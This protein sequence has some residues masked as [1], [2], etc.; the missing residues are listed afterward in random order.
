[1]GRGPSRHSRPSEQPASCQARSRPTDGASGANQ[2]RRD[3]NQLHASPV[4]IRTIMRVLL[5]TEGSSCTQRVTPRYRR[6]RNLW[7]PCSAR[8]HRNVCRKHEAG[9]PVLND[10]MEEYLGPAR[11]F[12][13][14]DIT[15]MPCTWRQC[16]TLFTEELPWLK[17]GDLE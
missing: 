7:H 1:M 12:W 10:N 4:Y 2:E 17:G 8:F 11:M 9:E 15:R 3:D 14:T 5:P 16:A 13:G 6:R